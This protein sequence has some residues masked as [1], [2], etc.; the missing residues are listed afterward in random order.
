MAAINL[1]PD[2]FLDF[3]ALFLFGCVSGIID[4]EEINPKFD[5][6]MVILYKKGILPPLH[7]YY[8]NTDTETKQKYNTFYKSFEK[9]QKENIYINRE[10]E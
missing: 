10:E 4:I 8:I 3:V 2:T 5:E 6:L 1:D 7:K 9:G